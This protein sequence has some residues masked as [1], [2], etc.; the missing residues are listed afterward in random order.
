MLSKLL[1]GEL[2]RSVQDILIH[3][4][5]IDQ[6]VDHFCL[7]L[8][9]FT[10]KH[11]N[12]IHLSIQLVSNHNGM[13]NKFVQRHNLLFRIL[14]ILDF[15][16]DELLLGEFLIR[17]VTD[18]DKIDRSSPATVFACDLLTSEENI[19]R[20][21]RVCQRLNSFFLVAALTA[22]STEIM[23]LFLA[24]GWLDRDIF[25]EEDQIVA[26]C[27]FIRNLSFSDDMKMMIETK[28]FSNFFSKW[29]EKSVLSSKVSNHLFG[30]ISNLCIRNPSLGVRICESYPIICL[31]EK[32]IFSKIRSKNEIIQ[33]L[34]FL[35]IL[36]KSDYEMFQFSDKLSEL[37]KMNDKVI[38]R[39]A[40][41]IL[42]KLNC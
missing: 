1:S 19:D 32:I 25:E 39:I 16:R 38:S 6:L 8:D 34:Q 14:E 41:E 36:I 12:F 21:R 27:Q 42:H 22:S 10:Q 24:D 28:I 33:I 23:S 13:K 29:I 35:R 11:P 17:I 9:T 20:T 30:T 2:V 18:D 5:L 7:S 15:E 31:I 40:D 4:K 26:K 37:S 3:T